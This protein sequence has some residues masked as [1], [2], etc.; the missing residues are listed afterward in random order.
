[1]SE[2]KRELNSSARRL[3]R[4]CKVRAAPRLKLIA[5]MRP[6]RRAR[7]G[8]QEKAR[9]LRQ[10]FRLASTRPG[11]HRCRRSGLRH[12]ESDGF[13]SEAALWHPLCWRDAAGHVLSAM[14]CRSRLRTLGRL[15]SIVASLRRESED[16]RCWLSSSEKMVRV[17]REECSLCLGVRAPVPP[18]SPSTRRV[19]PES[20][21]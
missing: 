16:L 10:E 14:R 21:S 20:F 1:V 17:P 7:A 3:T 4:S 5:R 11:D 2:S 8:L 15:A 12:C 18:S 6:W 9:A 19:A 13:Q